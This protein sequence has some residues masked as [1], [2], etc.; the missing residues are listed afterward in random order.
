MFRYDTLKNNA[1]ST[2]IE[3]KG[4]KSKP[5]LKNGII[6]WDYFIEFTK[7]SIGCYWMN[8]HHVYDFFFSLFIFI[9]LFTTAN[10][11]HFILIL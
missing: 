4:E 9:V 2:L 10:I 5:V 1:D 8:K 7:Y 11:S 3:V 6:M